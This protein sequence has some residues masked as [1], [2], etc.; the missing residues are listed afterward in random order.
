[1]IQCADPELFREA[2]ADLRMWFR[3][4][5]WSRQCFGVC[6]SSDDQP[7][8]FLRFDNRFGLH[9]TD[10]GKALAIAKTKERA[11]R[12]Q[13]VKLLKSNGATVANNAIVIPFDRRHGAKIQ[14]LR[15]ERVLRACAA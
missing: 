9:W 5:E 1:M 10:C 14:A 7:L 3:V 2:I 12:E 4:V 8:L 11:V 6:F 13:I 15:L